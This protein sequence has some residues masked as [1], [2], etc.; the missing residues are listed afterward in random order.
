MATVLF[1]VKDEQTFRALIKSGHMKAL[2]RD[3]DGGSARSRSACATP[4]RKS[5]LV[6]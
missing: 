5:G 2:R 6:C 3:Y 1:I 4:T